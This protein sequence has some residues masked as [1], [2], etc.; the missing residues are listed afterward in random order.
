MRKHYFTGYSVPVRDISGASRCQGT[1]AFVKMAGVTPG[2][3]TE[4]SSSSG[5]I[6]VGD[7]VD[8]FADVE[9]AIKSFEDA[10]GVQLYRRDTRKLECSKERYPGRAGKA[11]PALRYYVLVYCCVFGGRDHRPKSKSTSTSGRTNTKYL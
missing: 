5:G 6:C 2:V 9:V 1:Q 11:N 8:S 10:S 7:A 4:C 3:T